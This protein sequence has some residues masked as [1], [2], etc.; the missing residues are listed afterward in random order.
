MS[1]TVTYITNSCR[2]TVLKTV[3]PYPILR[4]AFVLI[5]YITI[6]IFLLHMMYRIVH[7]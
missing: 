7:V 4:T 3:T 2:K 6:S 5:V 1:F